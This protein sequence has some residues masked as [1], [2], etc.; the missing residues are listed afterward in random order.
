MGTRQLESGSWAAMLDDDHETGFRGFSPLGRL[1]GRKQTPG[2]EQLN[3]R[4]FIFEGAG[5]AGC[6][7]FRVSMCYLQ[8]NKHGLGEYRHADCLD[9]ED[10][11]T[12]GCFCFYYGENVFLEERHDGPDMTQKRQKN[13][14][15]K[16]P[17]LTRNGMFPC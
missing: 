4:P 8:S 5:Q 13:R 14:E 16:R 2:L 9:V 7:Q 1:T 10:L 15:V 11:R 12:N 6:Q 17:N 3:T